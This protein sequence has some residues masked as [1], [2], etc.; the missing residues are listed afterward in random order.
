MNAPRF[1]FLASLTTFAAASR[2]LPHPPN[3]TSV[4]AVA[5]FGAAT[6]QGRWLA[7]VVPLAALLSSDLVL[8]VTYL[9]GWQPARGFYRGQW[10]V[11]GGVMATVG[12]G[13]LLRRRR[14]F[15]RVAA[16][17]FASSLI[18][19]LTTNL[20]FVHGEGSL[21]PATLRGVLLS[22][23]MAL[24]FFRNSLAGDASYTGALF[25][26]LALAEARFSILR[27]TLA[28]ES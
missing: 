28:V 6:F 2:L 18:F 7:F 15:P 24:P 10:V 17:T 13:S 3:F 19:F 22:Y 12:L 5:L 26:M 27:R 11:Y 20:V 25:G 21:Y 14:T 16:A 23:E 8:H 9:A 4:A 1:W